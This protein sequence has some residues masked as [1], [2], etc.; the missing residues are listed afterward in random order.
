VAAKKTWRKAYKK[1]TGIPAKKGIS[2]VQAY[3]GGSRQSAKKA[4]KK[5]AKAITAGMQS[6]MKGTSSKK[7][8][9]KTAMKVAKRQ[10]KAQGTSVAYQKKGKAADRNLKK[11]RR[12][13]RGRKWAN[14][15]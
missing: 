10:A 15:Y 3:S 6:T 2:R 11:A 5:S 13:V 12:I 9:R 14:S 7:A 8:V 4:V 1:A